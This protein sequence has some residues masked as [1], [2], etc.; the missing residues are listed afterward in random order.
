[1]T[2]L[3]DHVQRGCQE[4]GIAKRIEIADRNAP[5]IGEQ[6]LVDRDPVDRR[7]Q[8]MD[9]QAVD[10]DVLDE[11][12]RL[13]AIRL[14]HP[15]WRGEPAKSKT[16]PGDDAGRHVEA[17]RM[18]GRRRGVVFSQFEMKRPEFQIGP[19]PEAAG[20]TALFLDVDRVKVVAA[21]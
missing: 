2:D 20:D 8:Y 12:F 4:T 6:L 17:E 19:Q 5:A 18:Q 10:F 16:Q 9:G 15:R 3:L 7:A 21:V 11:P 1:E 13:A 14:L